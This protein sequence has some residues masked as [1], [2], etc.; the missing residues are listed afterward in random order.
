MPQG[1]AVVFWGPGGRAD[2]RDDQSFV[3]ASVSAA[4]RIRADLVE[5]PWLE[6]TPAAG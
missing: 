3:H 1:K 2:D 6:I 5:G 4:R